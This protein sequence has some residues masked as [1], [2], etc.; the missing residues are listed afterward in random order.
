MG[1]GGWAGSEREQ[2]VDL[3]RRRMWPQTLAINPGRTR[4]SKNI[5]WEARFGGGV[6]PT[7]QNLPL[8][9]KMSTQVQ[10]EP[11]GGAHGCGAGALSRPAGLPPE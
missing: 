5:P 10:E 6:Y 7:P 9:T 11:L 4:R 1:I 8:S 2:G 3:R